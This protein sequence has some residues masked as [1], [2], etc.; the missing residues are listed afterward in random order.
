[1]LTAS[2]ADEIQAWRAK[3]GAKYAICTMD[4]ITLKTII[5]SNPGL[6]LLKQG[7]VVNKWA[8]RNLPSGAILEKPMAET[9]LGK[10]AIKHDFRT[11]VVCAC[12]L[13]LP[14]AL[15]FVFDAVSS[16]RE[17]RKSAEKHKIE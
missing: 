16:K 1:M 12:I 3:T 2:T 13:I 8:D 6:L 9:A 5:R 4:D 7:V 17:R 15:F 10:T 11:I 14:I